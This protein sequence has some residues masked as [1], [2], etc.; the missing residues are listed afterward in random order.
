M[1]KKFLLS[2]LLII[3]AWLPSFAQIQEPVKFKTELKTISDTE[4]QIVF[5]GNIDAGWH[6][7]S[8][9]LPSGGPISATFNVEKIQGAELMGKLTPQGKEIENFDKVFEMKLR[10]FENTATFVQKFKITDASYQIEGYLEYGA[11]NDENC[12]PPTEV[13]FSFSGKGNAATATVATSETK[14]ETVNQPAAENSVAEATAIDSAATVALSDNETSVQDYWTPVIKELNSYG[15]TTS[16]Q[17]RSWIYIFFAGFI[18]GLLALFTPCV[19]PIIPMTVSFFLKRS[20][21]KKKGIRDAWTYGASIVVIYV[22]LGLAITLIFGASA[23]NALSTNAVFNILFCLMLIIFAASF[24]GAFELTLP[25]KWSNAVDSKAEQ[26]SG[27][28]SIFLMAFTLSLVSFSCTGPII[29]FLLVEVSTT[30]SVIAPAIGMLGFAIALALP[31]T[32]FAMFPSWLKSM[33][34]SGGWMNVIKVTLGFLELAFALK[35]LSVADLAYGWRILDRETFLALWIVIFGLLGFYLLGKI[36]FPHD[37]DDNTTSVPRFFMALIS[38]AFAVYMVPGL[39]GA[40]LKAVS[41]FAPPMTTQD[42]NLY[43]N[44]VHAKFDDYD[45]G[46]EY[47]KRNGKPVMLDF[48]GYGCVN[49]RKME[50]AVWTDPKVSKLMTDDYVLITLYVDNKEPLPEHIKVMENGKERTLRTVG[51]KWSYLQ[52]SKFGANAQ[53]FYVLIDNEGKPLN[54]SYS[55]DEDID[56]YV[57]FLQTGLDNYKK[58]K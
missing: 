22:A 16:Q 9:D 34:K 8:T 55:Y 39:W 35:F 6:V 44:E 50:A 23:L 1:K 45:A 13:P 3:M 57:D 56:K 11:C 26:T 48:T 15:E 36:K 58:E 20:K 5:T 17:D 53:P 49:C 52:R 47:A 25:S 12:L 24:F 32:L 30:G 46:M 27:L 29:G 14:A 4:A 42:F 37:D 31:F 41:A 2:C 7:Y 33:P 21:D 10:Y 51:D 54:K 38:L 43:N 19:W 18:G 40:P 28:L